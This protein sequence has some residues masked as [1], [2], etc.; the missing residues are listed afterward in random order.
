LLHSYKKYQNADSLNFSLLKLHLLI[1]RVK[2][3]VRL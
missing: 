3:F 2:I 1:H